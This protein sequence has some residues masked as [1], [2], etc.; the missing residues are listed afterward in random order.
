MAA[1]NLCPPVRPFLRPPDGGVVRPPYS[2]RRILCTIS[3]LGLLLS[4]DDGGG[5]DQI[6]LPTVFSHRGVVCLVTCIRTAPVATSRPSRPPP[7]LLPPP[8]RGF[9]CWLTLTRTAPDS[10]S[11]FCLFIRCPFLVLRALPGASLAVDLG[12]APDRTLFRYGVALLPVAA[13]LAFVRLVGLVA[14][15]SAASPP[16]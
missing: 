8:L 1:L 15:V 6:L 12:L 10:T 9:G 14:A 4:A 2:A 5:G 3:L 11:L 16:S 7:L 13:T